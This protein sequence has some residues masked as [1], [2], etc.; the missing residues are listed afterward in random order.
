ML[1]FSLVLE[2]KL[3]AKPLLTNELPD[4]I[5]P[6]SSPSESHA[7]GRRA[8][9][10]DRHAITAKFSAIK[11]GLSLD[12]RGAAVVAAF[13]DCAIGR[14]SNRGTLVVVN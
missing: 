2:D 1:D 14:A 9:A 5:D 10:S 13:V 3:A 4:H 7:V 12:D 8:P 6:C 11:S